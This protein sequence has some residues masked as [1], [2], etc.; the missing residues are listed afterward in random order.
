MEK[1]EEVTVRVMLNFF[2][3]P[4][5]PAWTVGARQIEE[6]RCLLDT[7]QPVTS[8]E[9]VEATASGYQGFVIFNSHLQAAL[10]YKIRVRAGVVGI[11][12][13]AGHGELII[14]TAF[15]EDRLHLEAY[16][17]AQAATRGY[18]AALEEMGGPRAGD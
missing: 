9:E 18:A 15:Y 6:I 10:P 11:T 4:I 8:E 2:S 13:K 5:N 14:P 7:S 3:G 16:L 1:N 17:L 12:D